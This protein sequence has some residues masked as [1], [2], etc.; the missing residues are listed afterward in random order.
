MDKADSILDS[1]YPLIEKNEHS[2]IYFDKHH[3]RLKRTLREV[4]KAAS[5]LES[6]R[7]EAVRVLDV[8][9]H[10]LHIALGCRKLG[11]QVTG[12]DVEY[13]TEAEHIRKLSDTH[14]VELVTC[15]FARDKKLPFPDEYADL[16]LFFET[17]EHLNFY[18]LGLV[19]ELSRVLKPGG[20]LMITTPNQMSIG[21]LLHFILQRS[22]FQDIR[23]PYS[24]ATHYR[25]YTIR[26]VKY[27]MEA[28]GLEIHRAVHAEFTPHYLSRF[29]QIVRWIL[30]RVVPA[31][32]NNMVVMGRKV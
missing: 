10:E 9:S 25:L 23:Y 21:M 28:S 3:Q 7:K 22:Q 31:W 2:R 4:I 11:Y 30:T 16:V 6:E 14:Q 26:E 8:G 24:I 1:V 29:G 15:D 20:L 5:C 12:V 13:F 27:L 17:L 19:Q 18:P 32:S